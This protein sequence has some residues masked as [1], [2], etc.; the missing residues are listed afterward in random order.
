MKKVFLQVI[1][2]VAFVLVWEVVALVLAKPFILPTPVSVGIAFKELLL[3][4]GPTEIRWAGEMLG[5]TLVSLIRVL[6]GF[7]IA[8]VSGILIGIAIGWWKP[9]GTL[10]QP[11]IGLMRPIPPLAWIPLAML[12]FGLGFRPAIFLIWLGSFFPILSNT[13][14]GL[15]STSRTLL[16]VAQTLGAKQRHL[17]LKVVIPSATP[18]IMTGLKI[19]SGVGWMVLVAAELVG[20]NSGL[21]F[22]IMYYQGTMEPA[23]TIAGMVMIGIIGVLIYISIQKLENKLLFWRD[24]I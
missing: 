1:S 4:P 2:L 12:W 5:N 22:M 23:K 7:G 24:S 11:I 18:S 21:G 10:T 13:V 20:S 9:L 6:A 17:L 14:L 19:S 3:S 16:E 15:E 8:A